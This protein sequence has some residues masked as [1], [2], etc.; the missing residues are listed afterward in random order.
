MPIYEFE[1]SGEDFDVDVFLAQSSLSCT[2][3]RSGDDD[4]GCNHGVYV[5]SGFSL[6]IRAADGQTAAE[7]IAQVTDF[8]NLHETELCRLRSF[9]GVT[10][11]DL[12]FR[13]HVPQDE[14]LGDYLPSELIR[15]AGSL[16]L[17]IDL[18]M[19]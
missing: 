9:P 3:Y 10:R 18:V 16:G 8:L 6:T 2:P 4:P 17:G 11:L 5:H 13:Y 14:I 1:A 7:E 12:R 19:Y 15:L